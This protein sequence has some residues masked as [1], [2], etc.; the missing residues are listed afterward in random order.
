M[1][2]KTTDNK[3][4]PMF[5]KNLWGWVKDL[6]QVVLKKPQK[7][8]TSTNSKESKDIKENKENKE[9]KANENSKYSEYKE[10]CDKIINENKLN[11]LNE[12]KVYIDNMLAYSKKYAKKVEKIKDLVNTTER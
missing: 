10:F 7:L 2:Q 11:N 12:M 9:S 4:T 1:E 8:Q 3:N 5:I 6:V